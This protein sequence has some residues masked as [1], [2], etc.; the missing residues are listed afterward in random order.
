MFMLDNESFQ[1]RRSSRITV[2]KGRILSRR[3][4]RAR[5]DDPTVSTLQTPVADGA[6]DKAGA[7][8]QH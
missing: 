5:D 8:G 6:I 7:R 3:L 2:V 1:R 4:G